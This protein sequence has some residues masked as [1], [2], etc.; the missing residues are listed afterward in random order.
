MA[1][2]ERRDKVVRLH[3]GPLRGRTEPVAIALGALRSAVHHGSSTLIMV[4]GA[5][6]IGK[7]AML[8]EVC[9][10]AARMRL[11]V[12][13]GR[14]EP[15]RQ[16]SP[17]APVIAALRTGRS[18][19]ADAGEYAQIVELAS[20]LPPR[21]TDCRRHRV[22]RGRG[23]VLVSLDDWQWADQVSRFIM[24]TLPGRLM[25]L[26]VVWLF[27]SRDDDALADLAGPDP[28]SIDHIQLAPLTSA[29]LAAIAQDRL[30]HA[31]DERTLSFLAA[32]P[33]TRC[34]PRRSSM[35]STRPR[36]QATTTPSRCASTPPSPDTWRN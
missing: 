14:C 25:G 17:G 23:P 3:P 9:R 26:P 29:D 22:R 4:S 35:I 36:S 18:P 11:R 13:S 10:Q 30:G 27:A 5:P 19:L 1:N 33:E 32:E 28:G 20:Q 21:R 8:G 7:T 6:G 12:A 24:R 31:P 16:V 34:W 2:A 15:I